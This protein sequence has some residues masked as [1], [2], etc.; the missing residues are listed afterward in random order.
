[1]SLTKLV[2][3]EEEAKKAQETARGLFSAG[4]AANMP[5]AELSAA[6]LTD[7]KIHILAILQKSDLCPSKSKRAAQWNRAALRRTEKR[8]RRLPRPLM[9]IRCAVRALLC[10]AG[11]K[12]SAALC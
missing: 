2:H 4:G 7:G 10:A 3:G 8:L 1:M 9:Q 12:I 11:R 6:D 5:T